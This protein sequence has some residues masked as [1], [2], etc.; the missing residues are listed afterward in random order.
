MITT[1]GSP[2]WMGWYFIVA[3]GT[4]PGDFVLQR[5]HV[6][7]WSSSVVYAFESGPDDEPKALPIG[8]PA[9]VS[10]MSLMHESAVVR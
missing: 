9:R 10:P 8:I 5:V 7:D 4:R 1:V 6:L 2:T 3:R